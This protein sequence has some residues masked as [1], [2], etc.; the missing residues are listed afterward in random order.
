[1]SDSGPVRDEE[2]LA[3]YVLSA[4]WLYKD[5]R[6]GNP[7]RPNAWLPHPTVELSVFRTAG[8]AE[9][10]IVEQG[11]RVAAERE[12]KHRDAALLQ[13]REYPADKVTFRYHGRGEILANKVRSIGLGVVPKEPPPRHADIVNW[14]PL[15]GNRKH[16]EAAQMVFAIKLQQA[17]S[18]FVAA[19]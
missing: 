2:P 13:G 3:R 18:G 15:T 17:Q 16:D 19:V 5:G 8:W 1:M 6:A 10:Q 12:G 4:S 7:L 9:A 14:P 11:E